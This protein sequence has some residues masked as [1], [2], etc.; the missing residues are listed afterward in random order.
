[1]KLTR[2][3]K[4]LYRHFQK[5]PVMFAYHIGDL[6]DFYF[7]R[8]RWVVD[9]DGEIVE[10]ALIYN[11]PAT[12]TVLA[13]GLNNGYDRFLGTL[14]SE[15]PERFYG[16]YQ[17]DSLRI[18]NKDFNNL[19]LGTHLKMKLASDDFSP[20]L[21]DDLDIRP[22]NMDHKGALLELYGASYPGNYFD[23]RMLETGKYL[24]CFAGE[25]IVCVSGVHVH[26]DKYHISV[27]G[28]ITT[29]PDYRGRGLA[30]GVTARLLKELRAGGHMVAL[31][32]KEDNFAAISCYK[33]LGFDIYCEYEESLFTRI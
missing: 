33:K 16:H 15:L 23:D 24:G 18:F 20:R 26:S 28:N 9:D 25:E 3:K 21:R 7:G 31:N 29:R 22:L 2:D 11:G 10:A 6:D 14:L 13:F 12:P 8:C 1:V 32:V 17:K 19:P 30:S 27:L 5:D 4:A